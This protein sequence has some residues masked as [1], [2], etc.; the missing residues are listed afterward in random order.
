MNNNPFSSKTYTTTWLQHFKPS[1]QIFTFPFLKG[2]SFYKHPFLPLYTNLGKNMTKGMW[3]LI[4][5]A[6]DI[7]EIKNK[8]L[9]IYDVPDLT[10]A[11]EEL[12]IKILK[13]HKIP[14]YPGFLLK[15]APYRDLNDYLLKSFSYKSRSKLKKYSERLESS[16]NIRYKMY[17]EE[18]D[19]EEYN[20]VFLHFEKLLRK[21]FNQKKVANNNLEAKEWNFYKET[22]FP[23]ILN[24]EA[25]LFVI[26]KANIPIAVA[27]NYIHNSR[28]IG[29]LTVYDIDFEK[30]NLGTINIMKTI[31][32]ALNNNCTVFDFSKGD[33]KYKK[34]WT[35]KVYR[36]EYHLLYDST[37]PLATTIA[38]CI[39]N[40]FTLKQYLR[41][42][43]LNTKFHS[44]S[45]YLRN[46]MSN[47]DQKNQYTFAPLDEDITLDSC[48]EIKK[49]SEEWNCLSTMIIDFLYRNKESEND[50]SIKQFPKQKSHFIFIGK[51]KHALLT[52]RKDGT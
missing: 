28:L 25:T 22:S 11:K 38:W 50:L 2:I 52:L 12:P 16:F 23:M 39:K 34:R 8:V 5:T 35:N 41:D 17:H 49:Y 46:S 15:L 7:K 45:F 47:A 9:L 14:Q 32:W 27:L 37:S 18:I 29:A 20:L 36:F 19:K 4:N 44:L 33:Y 30:F 42:Q 31:E 24:K 26:Y 51:Q 13:R 1:A 6:S 3:Y 43:D 48:E 40:Y 21:R 10:N